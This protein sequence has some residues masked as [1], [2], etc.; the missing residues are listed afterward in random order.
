MP[1]FAQLMASLGAVQSAGMGQ[2]GALLTRTSEQERRD[3]EQAYLDLERQQREKR[4]AAE[5]REIKRGRYRLLGQVAGT[6]LGGGSPLGTAITTGLTSLTTQLIQ[7]NRAN[8]LK[9]LATVSASLPKGM[10]FKTGRD[11]LQSN[12]E[13][14]NRMLSSLDRRYEESIFASALQDAFSG[15]AL[16]KTDI[17]PGAKSL[18][19]GDIGLKEFGKIL[20][21]GYGG[22]LSPD[23]DNII[24]LP[25]V[26]DFQMAP[27][28]SPESLA[29]SAADVIDLDARRLARKTLSGI[30]SGGLASLLGGR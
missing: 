8:S 14:I 17:L 1:T 20:S 9:K 18:I 19:K 24:G 12:V 13:D 15:Y 4:E 2:T 23:A 28:Y 21:G 10:F 22:S 26:F 27:L 5:R 30:G 3:I 16:G 29:A 25:K 6:L 7:R 11:K